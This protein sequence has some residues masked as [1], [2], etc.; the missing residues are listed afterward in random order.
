MR[1]WLYSFSLFLYRQTLRLVSKFHAKAKLWSDGQDIVWLG[2]IKHLQNNQKPVFWIHSAS[3][4]E[5]EQGRPIVEN[6]R[7]K[8]PNH[9]ILLTFFSPSGYE[10]RKNYPLADFVSYLPLDSKSAA[11]KFLDIVR[12]DFAVFV[13]Y[14]FWYFY[15]TNLK[16]RNIPTILVSAIFRE[17]SVFF[18]WYGG[19]HRKMLHCYSQLFLQDISSKELL[20]KIG[21]ENTVVV[22][23]T[24]FDRVN[25]L[26]PK[27]ESWDLLDKFLNQ[28]EF[29]VLGSV[30]EADMQ[31]LIPIINES[32]WDLK[33][34][35]V[36]HEI[37]PEE[38][39]AWRNQLK[40]PSIYSKEEN[41]S[42]ISANKVLIVNE[43]GRL[44]SLYQGAKFA[45]IGGGFGAGLHNTLEAA[46]F[47]PALF[48]G[49]KNYTKFKE[50][51]DL[52]DLGIAFPIENTEELKEKLEALNKNDEGRQLIKK[53]S[54]AYIQEN[55]GATDQIM[56]FIEVNI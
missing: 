10:I 54:I 20:K 33:W 52:R 40:S 36:P 34:I 45:Y 56:N 49:N 37:H 32:Q 21:I 23:D 19:L 31:V 38:L 51:C 43:I 25:Q 41:Q 46:V 28:S 22:G 12:P 2:L 9:F 13:K 16:K 24:R 1:V 8:Y 30:W 11:T 6:I 14:E 42:N 55:I 4:G 47:G 35:I 18:K 17:E 48:F 27:V 39:E 3:L 7:E 44:S 15:L 29:V 50:A 5:F 53:K 26:A